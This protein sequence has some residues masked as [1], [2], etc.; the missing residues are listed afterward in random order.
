M[1][2][3]KRKN[4]LVINGVLHGHFPGTVEIVKQLVSL[5]HNVTCY[6]LDEF[7]ERIKNVGAKIIEF[8]IDRS[9]FKNLPPGVP[10]MAVSP[11]TI[12]KSY[13]SIITLISKDENIYD[14]LVLD[15]F[16]DDEV[17]IKFFKHPPSKVISIWTS[18]CLTNQEIDK[19]HNQRMGVLSEVNKKYNINIRDYIHLHYYSRNCNSK[20]MLTSKLFHPKVEKVDSSFIFIGPSIEERKIDE[21]FNFKKDINKKLIYVSFGTIFNQEIDFY[22][23]CINAFK[24]SEKYQVLMSIGKYNDIK[25]LGEIPSNFFIYNYVPQIQVLKMADFFFTHGGL[26]S[27]YEGLFNGLPLLIVPQNLDQFDIAQLISKLGA[28]ITLDK[29]NL[30]I[31]ILKDAV[32][33][34]E[35]NR[36]KYKKGVEKIVQSFNEDRNKRKEIFEKLFS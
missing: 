2:S 15:S 11:I 27:T 10:L 25:L 32:N 20:L 34:I 19:Y 5:G 6:V 30:T 16:F 28:G 31:D 9:S 23:L 33:N 13:N 26:N 12:T 7:V 18:F 21:T 35:N 29:N 17:L 1:Y 3:K 22:K 8:T 36:E 14:F 4:I 24:D